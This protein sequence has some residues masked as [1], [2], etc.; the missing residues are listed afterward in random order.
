LIVMGEQREVELRL[1]HR[2]AINPRIAGAIKAVP[3][4]LHVEEV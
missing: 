2:Y 3:G 4:V 1:P